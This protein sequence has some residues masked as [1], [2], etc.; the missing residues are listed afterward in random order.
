VVEQIEGEEGMLVIVT[1]GAK[2]LH[3]SLRDAEADEYI[4]T[5]IYPFDLF[6]A[7]Q[8]HIAALALAGK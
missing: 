6:T 1:V 3:V 7:E 5:K 8:V 2:G 4:G